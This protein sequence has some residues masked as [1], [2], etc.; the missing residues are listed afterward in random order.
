MDKGLARGKTDV[1]LKNEHAKPP[2]PKQEACL[3]LWASTESDTESLAQE[4]SYQQE[5][6][7]RICCHDQ[8]KEENVDGLQ[9]GEREE[10]NDREREDLQVYDSLDVA[11]HLFE[12]RSHTTSPTKAHDAH[13]EMNE[14]ELSRQ[15]SSDDAYSD[16][17]YDPNWRSKLKGAGYL[18]ES[19]QLFLEEEH[20]TSQQGN[21]ETE[22]LSIKGGYRYID[23]R[24]PALVETLHTTSS[25]S[26]QPYHLHPQHSQAGE[27]VSLPSPR[28]LHA[29]HQQAS[30]DASPEPDVSPERD[31]V[32]T[33]QS[34][35]LKSER[36]HNYGGENSRSSPES[37]EHLQDIHAR[38]NKEFEMYYKQE[39]GRAK[40]P[41]SISKLKSPSDVSR[42]KQEK[43]RE[44]IVERNKMT[45][46][47]N[48]AK[49]GSYLKAHA[50]KWETP[51]T[52]NQARGAPEETAAA[53]RLGGSPEDSADPE[54]RWVQKTQQL[55]VTQISKEKKDLQKGNP[56]PSRLPAPGVNA[57][58]GDCLNPPAAR[59]A[60]KPQPQRSPSS[61]PAVVHSDTL[62][63]HSGRLLQ[64]TAT[65]SPP[66]PTPPA[67]HLNINLN[68]STD[69]LPFLQHRGQ[70]GVITVASLRSP[71]WN[72]GSDIRYINSLFTEDVLI[73]QLPPHDGRGQGAVVPLP[74]LAPLT[75]NP[76]YGQPRP[77]NHPGRQQSTTAPKWPLS[78][79]E[80]DQNLS[81]SE[82]HGYQ[83]LEDSPR[84][85]CSSQSQPAQ[86]S[87]SY[88]V[89]PPIGKPMTGG[90]PEQSPEQSGRTMDPVQGSSSDGYLAHMERQKQLKERVTYKAYTLK[91]YRQLKQDV[92]LQNLGPDYA[93]IEKTAEK[94]RRQ[95]LYSKVIREQNKKISRIPF[96]P[97]EGPRGSDKKVPRRKALD[98]AKSIAMPPVQPQAKPKPKQ[99]HQAEGSV[100]RA[101]YLEGLDL[102]Q[103][104]TLELLRKRHEAEKQ[105]VA[106]FRKVHAI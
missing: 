1:S 20:L 105:T 2:S 72:P 78:F 63:P 82:V 3:N 19:L 106:C 66:E 87:A 35:L 62:S 85:P 13:Q 79:K 29:N 92:N 68:T 55:K 5:L 22:E 43:L 81:P 84:S 53:E 41:K 46:G 64:S 37:E 104:K 36:N 99:K 6:Q 9:Q 65:Q 86:H 58:P 11:A 44:D 76:G 95:K 88:V 47:R 31:K 89:L 16:L 30:Q 102:S 24:N 60:A 83:F 100:D 50:L 67:I 34:I 48:T 17:R 23:A 91:D 51:D 71:H 42:R 57:R 7:R 21:S 90:E 18:N 69:L 15:A 25:E 77:E 39:Q 96:L 32:S 12:K 74:A 14:T 40:Q 94:M 49:C 45:L 101:R 75:C 73:S 70:G 59:P 54:L 10:V 103:L 98:Y 52:L 4:R 8:T 28:H 93:A 33:S 80:E 26:N 61:Q 97:A 27:A 56:N 38:Y